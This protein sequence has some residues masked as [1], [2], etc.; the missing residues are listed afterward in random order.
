MYLASEVLRSNGVQ[1]YGPEV[2]VWSLG[3][4]FFILSGRYRF[5]SAHWNGVSL[6]G[7]L[8]MKRMLTVQVDRRITLTQILNHSWMQDNDVIIRVSS[9]LTHRI[10]M[11]GETDTPIT[12]SSKCT[13]DDD[14]SNSENLTILRLVA[15]GK[16]ALSDSFNSSEP[17]PKRFRVGMSCENNDTNSLGS[18][19]DE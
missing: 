4:I 3:V 5:S 17:I 11:M 18:Y 14:S 9:L 6:Q 13:E 1:C 8:L 15:T 10:D 12:I 16:R 7:K 19:S 2:D